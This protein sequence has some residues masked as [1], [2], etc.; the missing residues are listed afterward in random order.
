MTFDGISGVLS[1]D[2]IGELRGICQVHLHR[3]AIANILS[4]SQLRQMGHSITYNE[5]SNPEDDSFTIE[6]GSGQLR[7]THRANGTTLRLHS[8]AW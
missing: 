4:F 3:E 6:H 8:N 1:T 2:T 7:F 5:G